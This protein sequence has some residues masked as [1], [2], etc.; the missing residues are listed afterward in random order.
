MKSAR[1]I[2]VS[3][4]VLGVVV[5]GYLLISGGGG[6]EYKFVFQNSGQLVSGDQVQVG[7]NSVGTVENID[8]TDNNQAEVTVQLHDVVP[9]HQGTRAVV[10]QT[11]LLGVA[12]RTI[13]LEPGPNNEPEIP[14]GGRIAAEDTTS[15]VELDQIFDML[16]APTRRGL[17]KV[18]QGQATWYRGKGQQANESAKYLNPALSTTDD[19]VKKL[20]SDD[21]TLTSLIV[22]SSA[23]AG[24]LNNQRDEVASLFENANKTTQAIA[25]ENASLAEALDNLPPALRQGNSTL[26]DLRPAL[27]D[28]SAVIEASAPLATD[29]PPFLRSARGFAVPAQPV[30]ANLAQILAKRGSN[31]N[32]V[33]LVGNLPAVNKQ[34]QPSFSNSIAALKAGQPDI[35]YL[36]P[37]TPDLMAALRSFGQSAGYYDANGHYAR[38]AIAANAFQLTSGGSELTA[39]APSD[40]FN[41]L[42]QIGVKRCPGAGSQ[43][44]TDGSNPFTDGG[45]LNASDCDPSIVP[46]GP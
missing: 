8:L 2:V 25:S 10:R 40:R 35:E 43:S 15:I 46:P 21:S 16:D 33:Q 18:I 42:Q 38:V 44:A 22:K 41:G 28:L 29:L 9:L 17:Q 7:G 11:S 13:A 19:L 31:V 34:A 12:N 36:R 45:Q 30:F 32:A 39:Q 23:V 24:K 3:L 6:T 5:V 20:T 1:G 26:R 4:L 14:A 27:E 37:Y